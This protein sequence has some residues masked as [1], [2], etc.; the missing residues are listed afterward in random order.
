MVCSPALGAL[1]SPILPHIGSSPSRP[2]SLHSPPSYSLTPLS[3]SALL[4]FSPP[5][6]FISPIVCIK[7]DTSLSLGCSFHFLYIWTCD[8]HTLSLALRLVSV[9]VSRPRSLSLSS[10]R[11]LHRH[12]SIRFRVYSVYDPPRV[13][14][15]STT[16]A[17]TPG[18]H[19]IPTTMYSSPQRL[20]IPT[21]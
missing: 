7:T 17:P 15:L 13:S 18:M 9:R 2:P 4:T 21:S 10:S 8:R 1:L 6:R 11:R 19:S 12:R 20:V 3:R 16:L 5:P 14:L